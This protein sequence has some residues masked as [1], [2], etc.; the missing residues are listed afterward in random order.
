MTDTPIFPTPLTNEL[1][2]AM[3][4]YVSVHPF[5]LQHHSR[6]LWAFRYWWIPDSTC[7]CLSRTLP[8]EENSACIPKL[9]VINVVGLT[10]CIFTSTM[11]SDCLPSWAKFPSCY[12]SWHIVGSLST[13]PEPFGLCAL[14]IHLG[15]TSVCFLLRCANA[16]EKCSR[17]TEH[18][19]FAHNECQPC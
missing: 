4:F 6:G 13:V 9:Y 5:D 16:R 11:P 14:K 1:T 17:E 8:S 10:V 15:A 12:K 7:T 18:W 3:F 2:D 19:T